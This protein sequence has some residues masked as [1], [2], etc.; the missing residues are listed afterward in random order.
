MNKEIGKDDILLVQD[1]VSKYQET[2]SQLSRIIVGQ[3]QAIKQILSTMFVGGHSLLI[4][5]PGLAKTLLVNTISKI[6]G[7]RFNRVQFTPDLMPSDILGNDVLNEN[8]E[9]KFIKGPI[10]CNILLADEINR[11]PPKTQSALLEAM[12]EKSVT[13]SGTSLTI[14]KKLLLGAK[15]FLGFL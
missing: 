3:D 5:V 13:V 14:N 15:S 11:T 10:F 7:L 9:F 1:L 2:T 12:E 8:R 6:L 4:G